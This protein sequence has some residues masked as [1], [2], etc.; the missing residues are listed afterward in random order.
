LQSRNPNG[1]AASRQLQ[2]L[3]EDLK[4]QSDAQQLANAYK[5]RQMLDRQISTLDRGAK[6]EGGVSDQD[7]R[8]TAGEARQTVDQLKKT[9]EEAPTRDAFGQP[10]R[11]AL[12]GE[13]KADIDA[14]LNRMGATADVA[15]LSQRAGEARDAL[16]KVSAA[17]AQSEPK[18]LQR[19]QKSDSLQPNAADSFNQGMAELESL[20]R[21]LEEKRNLSAEDQAKQARQALLDLRTGAKAV[22]D[23]R[24]GADQILL[25]LDKTLK[26][27][28]ALDL[29]LLR[30]LQNQ[31]QHFSAEASDHRARKEDTPIVNNIDPASLP[32]AYRGRIQKYFQKLSEP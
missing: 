8:D 12:N 14:K 19:A 26:A 6:S 11:S 30:K 22:P 13:N 28:S 32:P 16:Q 7:L 20:I 25:E 3:S 9:A 10:L 1:P 4:N 18:S 2:K 5:L 15:P 23:N 27:D 17:F 21:Q 31:L 29:A 24:D